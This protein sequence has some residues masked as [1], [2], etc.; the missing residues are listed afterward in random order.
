[1]SIKAMRRRIRYMKGAGV[2]SMKRKIQ[3]RAGNIHGETIAAIASM[4]FVTVEIAK[5][6]GIAMVVMVPMKKNPQAT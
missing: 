3:R 1:M 6:E 5:M 2:N 4:K